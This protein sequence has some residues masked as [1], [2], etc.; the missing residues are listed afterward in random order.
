[1]MRAACFTDVN[2]FYTFIWFL[3]VYK[4]PHISRFQFLYTVNVML[5]CTSFTMQDTLPFENFHQLF[6]AE[7]TT[8][9]KSLERLSTIYNKLPVS[10]PVK[11]KLL[12]TSLKNKSAWYACLVNSNIDVLLLPEYIE[13][14]QSRNILIKKETDQ[15]FKSLE[16]FEMLGGKS[17]TSLYECLLVTGDGAQ[18]TGIDLFSSHVV[19]TEKCPQRLHQLFENWNVTLSS[20]TKPEALLYG[21]YEWH[22][23]N[24][25]NFSG[26]R[27][28]VLWLNYQLWKQYGQCALNINMEHYL[29]N[30][31]H[32]N[33]QNAEEAIRNLV[34]FILEETERSITM[35]HGVFRE[36]IDFANLKPGQK[37]ISGYL[38]STA[39]TT[40]LPLPMQLLAFMK[41]LL[42]KGYVELNDLAQKTDLEKAKT[43][44]EDLFQKG[45]VMMVKE[46]GESYISLNPS[47]RAQESRLT[48]YINILPVHRSFNWEEFA[49]QSI[50]KPIVP[51]A[52]KIS[53]ES[54][55]EPVVRKR[56]KAF[57]G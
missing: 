29:F 31:W 55:K 26:N 11:K 23:T 7:F 4:P 28:A 22:E 16:N 46:D 52:A 21:F 34:G 2:G 30:H 38:F 5:F 27:Q 3:V 12:E 6:A 37:L 54:E 33:E 20:F 56:Q 49:A 48:K 8:L 19:E 45:M 50:T 10:E 44:F 42:K 39:F 51:K 9:G 53:P 18:N 57:F 25:L 24:Q 13:S 32:R 15:Y 35:L 43:V 47:F 17:N 1:M 41:P 36:Y 40:I 14:R